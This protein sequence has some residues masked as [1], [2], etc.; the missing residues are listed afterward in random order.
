MS[1]AHRRHLPGSLGH[2]ARA[3]GHFCSRDVWSRELTTLPSFRRWAYKTARVVYLSAMN[4]VKD[5]C[6]WRASALTYITVLSLVPMLAFA[7]SVAKGLGAYQALRLGTIDPL[8]DSTFGPGTEKGGM[9]A[10]EL[11][12]AATEA[13]EQT[14]G[15][16]LSGDPS[17]DESAAVD[18]PP[19]VSTDTVAA[20][21]GAEVRDA[22]DTVL[23]FV[24]ETNVASLGAFGL[25]IVVWTVLSLLGS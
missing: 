8:L 14:A 1:P 7:F 13:G 5:R 15:E 10:S 19:E 4:F 6:T 3:V 22:I 11:P 21:Q 16:Q 9:A 18:S 2:R 23:H 12:A 17:T 20:V 25:V 24:Q